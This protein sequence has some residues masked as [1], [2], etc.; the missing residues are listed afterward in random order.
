MIQLLLDY[1]S[2]FYSNI[3]YKYSL[4][5][6]VK[7]ILFDSSILKK[8]IIIIRGKLY[9]FQARLSITQKDQKKAKKYINQYKNK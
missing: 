1:Y 9:Q 6:E 3:F 2:L 4:L 8:V 5:L 7:H